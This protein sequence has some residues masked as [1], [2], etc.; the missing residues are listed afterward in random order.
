[1]KL[2][3]A[4][5]LSLVSLCAAPAFCDQISFGGT[6]STNTGKLGTSHTYGTAP[7]TVTAYGYERGLWGEGT[8]ATDLYGKNG[9]V[10]NPSETGLGIAGNKDN[11]INKYSF[12]ELDLSN[13][14]SPFSLTIGSTQNTEGFN[15]CFSNSLGSLGSNCTDYKTP[16]SDPFATGYFSKLSGDQ[17][18]TIQ[19]DGGENGQGN[20]LLDGLNTAATPEPGSL[21]LLGTG[22]LGAAGA[23]RRRLSL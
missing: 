11:E 23:I 6:D 17:Y 2:K 20:V 16:G 3:L 1:M 8:S 19:A 7:E 10:N 4:I 9:G 21:I 12:I 18:I 13:I 15:V 5:A 22:I 14:N